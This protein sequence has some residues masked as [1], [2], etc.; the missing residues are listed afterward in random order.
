MGDDT[1]QAVQ[2][3]G[4][5]SSFCTEISGS[6]TLQHNM[7]LQDAQGENRVRAA[8][9]RLLPRTLAR[10]VWVLQSACH[11]L[12]GPRLSVHPDPSVGPVCGTGG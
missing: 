4:L 8:R 3:Q 5:L 9:G 11:R 6:P 1:P 12:G 7:N 2:L 10:S